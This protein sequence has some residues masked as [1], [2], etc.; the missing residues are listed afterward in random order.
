MI[1]QLLTENEYLRYSN[2]NVIGSINKQSQKEGNMNSTTQEAKLKAFH[3]RQ[4]THINVHQLNNIV[5]DIEDP[6]NGDL[7]TLI[8]ASSLTSND[9]AS[10]IVKVHIFL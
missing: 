8:T 9:S 1:N 5:T 3:K 4:K 10:T 7:N 6:N 2:A